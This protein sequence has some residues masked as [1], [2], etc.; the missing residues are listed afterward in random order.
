LNRGALTLKKIEEIGQITLE[1]REEREEEEEATILASDVREL[2]V[3][4]SI[5]LL[6]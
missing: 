3:L 4:P 6:K 2:F 5:L 1:A